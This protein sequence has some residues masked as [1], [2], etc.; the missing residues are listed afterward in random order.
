MAKHRKKARLRMFFEGVLSK[1]G[2]GGGGGGGG[3]AGEI[4][5]ITNSDRPDKLHDVRIQN[6]CVWGGKQSSTQLVTRCYPTDGRE[7]PIITRRKKNSLKGKWQG[8]GMGC[9]PVRLLAIR[10][11]AKNRFG[12]KRKFTREQKGSRKLFLGCITGGKTPMRLKVNLDSVSQLS[13][14]EGDPGT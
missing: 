3:G 1:G 8:R 6:E 10:R 11:G 4:E 2:W 5:Q 7:M 14:K 12:F 13:R 9:G